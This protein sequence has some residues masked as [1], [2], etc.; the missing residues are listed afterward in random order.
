MLIS[1]NARTLPLAVNNPGSFILGKMPNPIW[2]GCAGTWRSE[3]IWDND[4][5]PPGATLQVRLFEHPHFKLSELASYYQLNEI[6]DLRFIGKTGITSLFVNQLTAKTPWVTA[7]LSFYDYENLNAGLSSSRTPTNALLL[8]PG[9]FM[10]N[11]KINYG[12]GAEGFVADAF[13]MLNA[14]VQATIPF[15]APGIGNPDVF[16]VADYIHNFKVPQDRDGLRVT[17]GARMGSAQGRLQPLTLWLTYGIVDADATLATF[18][19][20]ELGEGTGYSGFQAG[21]T[22]RV[23]QNL[24]G[25]IQFVHYAGA[26]RRE[27]TVQRVLVDL[28]GNF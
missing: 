8:R 3:M 7:A 6:A 5:S 10:T 21:V 28:T 1:N 18:A 11:N 22:Y 14:T 9:L 20:S 26:P 25:Q 15:T 27:N 13:R 16:L 4:I 19:D 12:P 23:L 24:L 17:A 2:R